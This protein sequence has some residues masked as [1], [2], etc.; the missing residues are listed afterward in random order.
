M[1]GA[2]LTVGTGRVTRLP[3]FALT[4]IGLVVA[5]Q[6][7]VLTA[8]S[9][10]Y[11]FHRDELYFLAA[12][13]R[14]AWGYIDQPPITPLLARAATA[15]FGATP[16]GLRVAATLIGAATVVV[17]A[18][19]AREVG[20]GRGAQLLAAA[21]T[22]LSSFVLAVSHMLSTTTVDLLV[23]TVIGLLALRLLR[24]GDPR[25]WLALGAAIGLGLAN[26]WLVLLLVSA[27][28]LAVLAVGPRGVLRSGWLLAGVGVS[29]LLAGP[30]F[31]ARQS[32]CT[33]RRC[34]SRQLIRRG[35]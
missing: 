34:A 15:L 31:A 13:A 4:P 8:L 2:A 11:G 17:V 10:R 20:G 23:W 25:W 26:K 27:L 16:S 9:G 5:A 22:A 3:R 19:I 12:G 1:S 35:R 18:L 24:T 28:G 21:A 7:A 29:A 32:I 30:V 6:V 33:A 14:P